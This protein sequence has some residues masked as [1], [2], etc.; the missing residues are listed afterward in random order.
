M[1]TNV[2]QAFDGHIYEAGEDIPDL[3]SFANTSSKKGSWEYFGLSKD[4]SKLPTVAKY[5]KY[6]DLPTGA[7]AYCIDNGE[8]YMYEKTTDSWIKQ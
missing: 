5:P 4:V 1:I 7:I 8:L 3:G 6:K 2:S